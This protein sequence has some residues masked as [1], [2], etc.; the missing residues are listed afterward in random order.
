MASTSVSSIQ[1]RFK[2]DVFLSFRGEDTRKTIVDH[3]Y[4][5]LHNRGIITYK[6]DEK[7]EKGKRINDQLLRSIEDSRIYIIVFSKNYASSSWCLDELVQIMECHKTT[8]RTAYPVFFNVEPTEVRHQSGVVKEAFAKHEKKEAAGKWRDAMKAAADLAG[9]ELK[10]TFDGH[11]A[12]FIQKIVEDISLELRFIDSSVDEKLIGMETRVKD[13]VSNIEADS[14]DVHVIGIKGI[15]GGGKTTLARAV[16]NYISI[17]YEGK[18]FVENVREASKG[19]GLKKLQQQVLKDVLN[20]KSIDITSVYEGEMMMKKMLGSRK[21]L[22]VLDDVDDIEQLEA[23]AGENTWFKPGST[24]IITT[25]DEHVL[26]AHRVKSIHDVNLLSHEEGIRLF[27]KYAFGREIPI[28]GYEELSRKVVHYAAGLPLTIKVLGSSLCGKT[29]CEWSDAIERLKTIPEKQTLKRLELSFIGLEHDHKE[30]FLEVACILKG[31]TTDKAI[32]ILESCGFHARFALK[33]LEQKSL[34]TVSDYGC[35]HMHDRLEE[36]GRNIVRR[37]HPRE[38]QRHN[39]LWDTKEIENILVNEL[40]LNELRFLNI[41]HSKLRTFDLGLTPQLEWLDLS[42]C[43]D[44]VELHMPVESL[45]LKSLTLSGCMLSKHDMGL[46][47]QLET[48]DLNRCKDLVEFHM[49]VESPK[50][51]SLV[52]N[53]SKLS[54][55]DLGVTPQLETLDLGECKD[56]VELHMPVECLKLYSLVLS[57]SKL[58]KFDMRLTPQLETFL[59]ECID[60]VELHMP[61]E[62]P[63]LCSLVLSGSKLSKLDLGLTPQLKTLDLGGCKDLV[64]LHMPTK[65]S[66]LKSLVISGSKLSKLNLGLTP[67]LERLDLEKCYY[68]QEIH[69]SVGSL[70]NLVNLKLSGCLGFERFVGSNLYVLP[71][72]DSLATLELIAESLDKCQLHPNNN[73]PKFQ[74]KCFYEDPLPSSSGNLEKLLSF[75]MCACTN[76]ESFPASIC[77]LQRLRKLTLEGSFP[78]VPK[79][80]YQ[81]ESLQEL[82]LSMKEIKHL[83]DTICMLKHLKYLNLRSC[84]LLEQLP[85]N[86]GQ[87]ECLEMLILTDCLSLQDIPNNICQIRSLEYLHIPYCILVDK[88]PE[89]LGRLE[90]LKELNIEGAGISRLPQ[91]IFESKGLRIIGTRWRLESYGF[92]SLS[93]VSSNKTCCYVKL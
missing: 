59:G 23:L 31:E 58:S 93:T 47:P 3:L 73:L 75:G 35:I 26:V 89:E 27:S 12:K 10:T 8:G 36:M 19:S 29:E 87:L 46:I 44:F 4:H 25:R 49:P 88:L 74:F 38:P 51:K 85:I 45:K 5:A 90:C 15:G 76:L 20:D 53:G 68:L 50:L 69:A 7:I 64:E 21:V 30:V 37:L 83:P 16:F 24:I 65:C 28:E 6:D 66:T 32:R 71:C 56:L 9:R 17:W 77:S 82:T 2:Y 39:R 42:E 92:T 57:G 86:L 14:D 13:V 1:K 81:L 52:L 79:D 48:L 18:S 34:M 41:S 40:V 22:I 54:K 84:W 72:I 70:E 91:S 78:E 33:V 61:I 67:Q 80:L 62:C 63:K 60:L 43:D 55:L 11:E